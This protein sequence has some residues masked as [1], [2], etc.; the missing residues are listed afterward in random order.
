LPFFSVRFSFSDLPDFFDW[1]WRGDLS[2]TV[3]CSSSGG[4]VVAG[5]R[6]GRRA[7]GSTD[8]RPRAT[9]GDGQ[10]TRWGASPDA[11]C[12]SG[13]DQRVTVRALPLE[14]CGHRR[15]SPIRRATPGAA[16]SRMTLGRT[17]HPRPVGFG[18]RSRWIGPARQRVPC[19]PSCPSGSKRRRPGREDAEA[20]FG[21]IDRHNAP[22]AG[23]PDVTV[24]EVRDELSEPVFGPTSDAWLVGDTDGAD[25]A[26]PWGCT[27]TSAWGR[28][29]PS[30]SGRP[31]PRRS[32]EATRVVW[33]DPPVGL[34]PH[35]VR[36]TSPAARVSE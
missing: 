10:P 25:V 16:R 1:C 12:F 24:T 19:A 22:L 33:L 18:T 28:C 30:T 27:G 23:S 14:R 13:D 35:I 6:R 34:D 4:F 17:L 36:P 15:C 31:G 29:W 5:P 26:P 8:L 32:H 9:P 3:V 21:V 20:I 2:A 11:A 7:G